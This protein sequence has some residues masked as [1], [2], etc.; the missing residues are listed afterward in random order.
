M[1]YGVFTISV[2]YN[3]SRIKCDL[4]YRFGFIIFY[5]APYRISNKTIFSNKFQ[6]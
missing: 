6:I 3:L 5:Q 4:V 2:F 1:A